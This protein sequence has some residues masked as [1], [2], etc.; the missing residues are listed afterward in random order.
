MVLQIVDEHGEQIEKNEN[1]SSQKE[2]SEE[3]DSNQSSQRESNQWSHHTP[4]WLEI[5]ITTWKIHE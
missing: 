2:E 1:D 4:H 5:D 3:P